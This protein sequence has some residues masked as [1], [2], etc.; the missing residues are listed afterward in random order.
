MFQFHA[1][2]G[3]FFKDSLESHCELPG[4]TDLC[5]VRDIGL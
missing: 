5:P 4:R 1:R 3:Y 2:S